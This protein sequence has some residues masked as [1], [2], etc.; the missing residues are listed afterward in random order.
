MQEKK[1]AKE[2]AE[3]ECRVQLIIN[4][5]GDA[6]KKNSDEEKRFELQILHDAMQ[7]EKKAEKQEILQKELKL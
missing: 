2:T 7:K 5:M 3:R 6:F 1:R 4:R